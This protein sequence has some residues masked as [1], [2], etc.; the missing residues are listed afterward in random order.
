M[1]QPMTIP[2]ISPTE[3]PA[4]IIGDKGECDLSVDNHVQLF[5]YNNYADDAE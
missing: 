2:T 5:S 4:K 3:R 1:I